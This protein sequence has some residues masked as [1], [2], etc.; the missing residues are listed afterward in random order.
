M[1]QSNRVRPLD[2]TATELVDWQQ[3]MDPIQ[4]NH[5]Q[6]IKSQNIEGGGLNGP[7]GGEADDH[8]ETQ[9]KGPS[10]QILRS[11]RES[12]PADLEAKKAQALRRFDNSGI[13]GGARVSGQDKS[14]EV[15]LVKNQ[16][17]KKEIESRR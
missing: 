12:G 15:L 16:E 2:E 11:D 14:E 17:K 9:P 13:Q 1:N 4:N 7:T 6:V 10:E 3:Y 5:S 8:I